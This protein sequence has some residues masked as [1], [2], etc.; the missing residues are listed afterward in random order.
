M[1]VHVLNHVRVRRERTAL[2]RA[3][4]SRPIKVALEDGIITPQTVVFDY[5]CGHGDDLRYL[6]SLGISCSGWDPAFAPG[7]ERAAANVVNLG[8]VVNVIE[9]PQ[10]RVHALVEAWKLARE[11]LIVSAR[12]S[13]DISASRA[14]T[15]ADGFIT[16]KGTFQKLFEQHE[17]RSWIDAALSAQSV[18]AAPGIFYVF[19]DGLRRE[20]YAAARFRRAPSVIHRSRTELLVEQSRAEFDELGAFVSQR[21]RL[22]ELSEC[23]AAQVLAE[24]IGSLKR[25]FLVLKRTTDQSDWDRVRTLRSQDLLVYLALGRFPKRPKFAELPEGTRLDIKAFFGNYSQ[26]CQEADELL[27]SAGKPAIV[28][29]ACRVAQVGKLTG[30]ALYVHECALSDLPSVLRV[31]EG[32]ARV[33]V[34]RVEGG[35]IVKLHRFAPVISYVSYPQFEKVAH[36]PLLGSLIVDLQSLRVRYRDYSASRNR[37]I[38]H[39][40]EEFISVSHPLREKFAKLTK[41]EER[42]QLFDNPERIGYEDGWQAALRAHSVR[43][44]GHRLLRD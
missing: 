4:L 43:I 23:S 12:L 36:P 26:A 22:P 42:H 28:D 24:R 10:E 18:A 15:F 35:N 13:L 31:Y 37:P 17:L 44:A 11:V 7:E 9:D 2:R 25:A 16:G 19:K 6:S 5:G 32:C 40:K 39:R 27:F 3:G 33:L 30:D 8:Y 21:G 41:Q 38:L 20:G 1:S 29:N 34:G 14:A